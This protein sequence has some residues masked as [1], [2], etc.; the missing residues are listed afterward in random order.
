MARSR[1]DRRNQQLR[2]R[3]WARRHGYPYFNTTLD[4]SCRP[5]PLSDLGFIPTGLFDIAVGMGGQCEHPYRMR[6]RIAADA[7]EK[8]D[9]PI[10]QAEVQL[11]A[12]DREPLT[13]DDLPNPLSVEVTAKEGSVVQ[14]EAIPVAYAQQLTAAVG[15]QILAEI[16]LMRSD[17]ARLAPFIYPIE[18]CDGCLTVCESALDPDH[19]STPDSTS[20]LGCTDSAGADGHAC[21][22]PDC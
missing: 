8:P 21:V 4:E 7:L 2:K 16:T 1:F 9:E 12:L 10:N 22:D 15:R 20:A 6:P 14:L 3:P 11:T 17:G 18:I 13:F 5:A 19:A